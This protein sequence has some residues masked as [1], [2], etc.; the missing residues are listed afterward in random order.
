[1]TQKFIKLGYEMMAWFEIKTVCKHWPTYLGYANFFR[2]LV[3]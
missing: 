1:V 2:E 3:D